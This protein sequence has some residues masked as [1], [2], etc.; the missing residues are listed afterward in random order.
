MFLKAFKEKSNKK[1]VNKLLTSRRVDLNSG[2]IHSIGVLLNK[3]EFDDAEAFRSYFKR[4]G[5]RS[6]RQSVI[7]YSQLES[8]QKAQWESHFYAKDFGW[9]GRLKNI[10][11]QQFVDEK[12]DVLIAYYNQ[13]L[14]ELNQ[15][16][17]MSKAN[18]K[19]GIHKGDERLFDLMIDISIQRF[20]LFKEEFRKYLTRLNKL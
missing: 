10:E 13:D 2:K 8:D 7:Y 18:F 12:F 20:D 9:K 16:V 19:V 14:L 1:Y 6:P 4:L 3:D 15:I 17:A 11:L 5:L